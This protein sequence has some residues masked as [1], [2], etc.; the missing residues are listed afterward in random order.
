MCANSSGCFCRPTCSFSIC[1][2]STAFLLK[3][4]QRR[5]FHWNLQ[6]WN[7]IFICVKMDA[8]WHVFIY[9]HTLRS[10]WFSCQAFR[11]KDLWNREHGTRKLPS[12]M[13]FF[14]QVNRHSG[15]SSNHWGHQGRVLCSLGDVDVFCNLLLC[16]TFNFS[17]KNVWK[18]CWIIITDYIN[19]YFQI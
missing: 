5:S 17:E 15:H 4:G 18:V 7:E 11:V 13:T 3:S 8:N 16:L 6:I 12:M 2:S 14:G 9:A 1:G 10:V 19:L